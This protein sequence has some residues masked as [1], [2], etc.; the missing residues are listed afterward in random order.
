MNK[1]QK[2]EMSRAAPRSQECFGYQNSA[3]QGSSYGTLLFRRANANAVMGLSFY[4]SLLSFLLLAKPCAPLLL[5]FPTQ[6][7]IQEESMAL[8]DRW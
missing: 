2:E 7:E 1:R 5:H 8:S 3:R 6:E 4:L